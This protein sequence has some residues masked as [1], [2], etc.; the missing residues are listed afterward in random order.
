MA[1]R[2][3]TDSLFEPYKNLRTKDIVLQLSSITGLV[4]LTLTQNY[5]SLSVLTQ[6]IL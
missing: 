3:F 5:E 6:T 4:L 2:L 1:I